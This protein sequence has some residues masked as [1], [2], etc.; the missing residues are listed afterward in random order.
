MTTVIILLLF[1][2]YSYL[3]SNESNAIVLLIIPIESLL[4]AVLNVNEI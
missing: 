2:I 3:R 1:N 4:N